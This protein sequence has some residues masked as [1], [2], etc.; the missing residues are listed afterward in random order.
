MAAM[1]GPQE[2]EK[3]HTDYVTWGSS[4]VAMLGI[5]PPLS[6]RSRN[7]VNV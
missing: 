2:A 5:W 7:V 1:L 6:G 4:W 3:G